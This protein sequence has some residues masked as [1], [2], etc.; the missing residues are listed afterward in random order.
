MKDISQLLSERTDEK[1]KKNKTNIK[2]K[3]LSK[4]K[5]RKRKIIPKNNNNDN[6]INNQTNNVKI[7][8]IRN[9]GVDLF[10]IIS[11]TAI[12]LMHTLGHSGAF[13]KFRY[14]KLRLFQDFCDW[15]I[16]GFSLISGIIGYKTHKYSNLLYLWLWVVFYTVGIH[17]YYQKYKRE[18]IPDIKIH[19]CLPVIFY[20]YWY[21]VKYFG[22]YFYLPLINKGIDYLTKT[23]LRIAVISLH[24][25]MIIWPEYIRKDSNNFNID[26][27]CSI[28]WFIILY[29]T[30]GYI[31]KYN[32]IYHGIKK[33]IYCLICL[34][35]F[36]S[37]S[38]GYHYYYMSNSNFNNIRG[39]YLRKIIVFMNI[40]FVSK[41]ASIPRMLQAVSM[42]LFTIQ[43]DYNKYLAKIITFFGPLT[44]G[45]YLIHDNIILRDKITS[46]LLRNLSYNLSLNEVVKITIIYASKI[47]FICSMIDYARHII[48]TIFRVRKICILLEKIVVKILGY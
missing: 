34:A 48:F 28:S 29:V 18:P 9:P 23:E 25:I 7:K 36:I 14:H 24:C 44:F 10:R 3:I 5:K 41:S 26:G 13:N 33:Y 4:I 39:Y 16:N 15:H 19:E 12:V 27:G 46:K 42:A 6:N 43:L 45:I 30:G 17:L 8:K 21:F 1:T 40:F 31:G 35:I 37:T 22:M 32:V 20:Q 11:M 38:L 47:F 2:T